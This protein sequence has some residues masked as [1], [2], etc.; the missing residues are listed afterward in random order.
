MKEN[1][2]QI[3]LV[4]YKADLAESKTYQSLKK[5]IHSFALDYD[6]LIYNN[7]PEIVIPQS[8]EYTVVNASGNDFLA[9]A[10]NYALALAEKSG[11]EW[12]LLLDQ[13]T[14]ITEDYFVELSDFLSKRVDADL[15]AVV[16]ALASDETVLSPK[17]ISD[18]KW[19]HYEIERGKYHQGENIIAYNSLALLSVEFM[20]Q[21][22]GF[23][24]SYPLDMLDYSYFR[25]IYLHNKKIYVLNC[26]LR[27]Y[28]SHSGYEENVS[29]TRHENY[30]SAEKDFIFN[31]LGRKYVCSYRM[32]LLRRFIKQV[33]FFK[34]K[35]YAKIT[36]QKLM[37]K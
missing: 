12:M 27:H 26:E 13:D 14:E 30:L 37:S 3:V 36:L 21:I 29:I 17:R 4:L 1:S 15:V 35:A 33:L 34:N 11:K 10:Y 24:E 19:K 8:D 25:Q 20:R 28:L 22:G 18:R 2:I 23:S 5:Y 6:V 16:P 32:L 7:S 31:E 9:G